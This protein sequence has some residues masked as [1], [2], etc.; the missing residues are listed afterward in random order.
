[1]YPFFVSYWS[2]FI[3]L[4]NT[5]YS[6]INGNHRCMV[7]LSDNWLNGKKVI[8]NAAN[9]FS[10]RNKKQIVGQNFRHWAKIS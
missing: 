8:F 4:L 6:P 3:K 5:A 2:L 7:N 1:M 9:L 10:K